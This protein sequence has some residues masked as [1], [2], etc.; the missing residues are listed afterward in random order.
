MNATE[1]TERQRRLLNALNSKTPAQQERLLK[2]L[3]KGYD[4]VLLL[5]SV[6]IKSVK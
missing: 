3:D 2:I 6:G 1:L 4:L 5:I